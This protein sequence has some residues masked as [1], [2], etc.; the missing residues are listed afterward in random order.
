MTYWNNAIGIYC[1]LTVHSESFIENRPG[2][3]SPGLHKDASWY[4]LLHPVTL[5]SRTNRAQTIIQILDT[6]LRQT[7]TLKFV[8]EYGKDITQEVHDWGQGLS[9][10]WSS[11]RTAN[12]GGVGKEVWSIT[13]DDIALEG[14]SSDRKSVIYGGGQTI[15]R[16]DGKVST[17]REL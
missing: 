16:S 17:W 3:T 6:E 11:E 10:D 2:N 5:S 12:P 14:A 9:G 15:Q 1:N 8:V 7:K 4:W 13:C